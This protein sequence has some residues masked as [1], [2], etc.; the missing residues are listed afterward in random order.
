MPLIGKTRPQLLQEPRPEKWLP[1]FSTNAHCTFRG[2]LQTR[3]ISPPTGF[4]TFSAHDPGNFNFALQGWGSS[5]ARAEFWDLCIWHK[6]Q[7]VN[8]L[9]ALSKS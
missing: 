8:T 4:L 3:T 7:E 6:F 5:D 9:P 1:T 2:C